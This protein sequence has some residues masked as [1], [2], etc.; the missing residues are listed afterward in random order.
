MK[1]G[2]EHLECI[3]E[4]NSEEE[5]ERQWERSKIV[6]DRFHEY[7]LNRGLKERTADDRTQRVVF[8]VMNYLFVY[9]DVEN[10]LE[11]SA[12]TIR[13]FL[14]N[15]YIRKFWD[16]NMPEIK[17]F[18]RAIL[19]FYKFLVKE[20]LASEASL[21][22]MEEVCKDVPWFEMRLRTYFAADGDEFHEWLQEYNYDW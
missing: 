5:D 13:T 20:G 14:G 4:E 12:D 8:Y 19:D 7:L 3:K 10:I 16:P 18:L 15:W 22:E 21:E 6:F 2:K 1:P 9:E 11:A 17:S